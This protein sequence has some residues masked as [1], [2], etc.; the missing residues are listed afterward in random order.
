[1][2]PSASSGGDDHF[3]ARFNTPALLAASWSLVI[4][5]SIGRRT[6]DCVDMKRPLIWLGNIRTTCTAPRASRSL[7]L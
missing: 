4:S 5:R 6:A 3:V 2:N 1:M 7:S